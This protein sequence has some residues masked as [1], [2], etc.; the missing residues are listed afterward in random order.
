MSDPRYE[1]FPAQTYDK[2]RYGDTDRQGHVNNAVFVT[3][4]ETGRTQVL[5]QTEPALLK[6]GQN[7][8]IARLT[9]EYRAELFWPGTVEIG[10]CVQAIGRSSVTF[11]QALFQEGK[12]AAVADSVVVLVDNNTH[13]ATP[14]DDA[15]KAW[16]TALMLKS[17][18]GDGK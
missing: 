9:L 12:C 2:L 4:L 18:G 13:R 10:T 6:P 17:R 11:G 1:D 15:V 16:L 5:H 8:V 14:L 3:L 7:F